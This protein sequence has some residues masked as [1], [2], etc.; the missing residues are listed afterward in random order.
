MLIA[1]HFVINISNYTECEL[2]QTHTKRYAKA[3]TMKARTTKT[4]SA[5]IPTATATTSNMAAMTTANNGN[6]NDNGRD[7]ALSSMSTSPDLSAAVG[8]PTP[9]SSPDEVFEQLTDMFGGSL[10]ATAILEIGNRMA[11]NCE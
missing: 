5:P 3:S 7:D 9:P 11:W 4:T 2:N 6:H 10:N 8:P 1:T